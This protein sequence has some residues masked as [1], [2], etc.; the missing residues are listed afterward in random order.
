MWYKAL[1]RSLPRPVLMAAALLAASQASWAQ[2]RSG[3][4]EID[5]LP[6]RDWGGPT[7]PLSYGKALSFSALV[8]GG[9]Q[10]YGHHPVRGGFLVGMETLLAGLALWSHFVD[11]PHWRSQARDAFD[12]ADQ[13]FLQQSLFPDSAAS[14]EQQRRKRVSFARERVRLAAQQQDLVNSEFAWAIGLHAYGVLDAGEIAW[15][16]RHRNDE[17]RSVR[18]AMA[19]G[20]LLP[21]GGQ[22]YNNRYGKF[23]MLWMAIGASAVSSWSRQEMVELFNRRL[24][25]ARHDPSVGS[26]AITELE[27]DRTLYRK[28]RNQYYWGIGLLYVYAVLDGMVDA[29]LSDF[30]APSRFAVAPSPEGGLAM[31]WTLP[32]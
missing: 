11:I 21:G 3:I 29:S 28:R 5:S 7:E 10:F 22:L 27:K 32:F 25:V 14:F 15:R 16:S 4:P 24:S 30:D 31:A 17:A 26:D 18:R 13:L 1:L 8:P 9:G 23:G 12:E 6:L 2:G 20:L 19:F